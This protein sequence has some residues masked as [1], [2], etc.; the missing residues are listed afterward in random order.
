MKLEPQ[1]SLYETTIE[2]AELEAALEAREVSKAAAGAARKAYT[3]AD[4][5]TKALVEPLD[6]GNGAPVRVGRF[7]LTR[8]PVA[9]RSVS[10]DTEPTT[11]LTIRTLDPEW[12]EP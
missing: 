1:T 4:E 10:F 6:L 8:R 3:E 7:V 5:H 2:N 9:A 11:R 12:R